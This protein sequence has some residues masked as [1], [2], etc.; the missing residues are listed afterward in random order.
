MKGMGPAQSNQ[1]IFEVWLKIE[2][3]PNKDLLL[4]KKTDKTPHRK[5]ECTQTEEY[6]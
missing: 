2:I 1:N 3:L 5:G 6:P 4:G